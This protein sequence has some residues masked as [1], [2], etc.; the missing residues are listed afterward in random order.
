MI[1]KNHL[2]TDSIKLYN[3]IAVSISA[4]GASMFFKVEWN[5]YIC[6]LN[7]EK[8]LQLVNLKYCKGKNMTIR[9]EILIHNIYRKL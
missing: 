2:Y 8:D 1:I 9:R 5:S 7:S 4:F 3:F 6:S